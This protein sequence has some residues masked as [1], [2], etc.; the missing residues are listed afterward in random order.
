MS[1]LVSPLKSFYN[2]HTR[3]K[4]KK[5][6]MI[7]TTDKNLKKISHHEANLFVYFFSAALSDCS[8]PS[9]CFTSG[10]ESGGIILVH[11]N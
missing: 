1:Q 8:T 10:Y 2:T 9:N 7:I 5:A 11:S 6:D 4:K 3:Q